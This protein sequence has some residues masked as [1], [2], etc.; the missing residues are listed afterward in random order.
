LAKLLG[1]VLQFFP[2]PAA[3]HDPMPGGNELL[4][5]FRTD[6]PRCPED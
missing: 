3:H 2:V 4:A 1:E 6:A 5:K